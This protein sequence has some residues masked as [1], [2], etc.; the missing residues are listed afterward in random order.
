MRA[1]HDPK[2]PA[3][4]SRLVR[5]ALVAAIAV[6]AGMGGCKPEAEQLP[7]GV[8]TESCTVDADCGFGEIDHEILR[9]ADCL[10]LYGCPYLPLN[11]VSIER[12]QSQYDE[13]CEPGRNGRGQVCPIDDCIS[14]PPA[15]CVAGKC[16]PGAY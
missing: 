15:A 3:R 14:P 4:A 8:D 5:C 7:P 16:A 2:R 6:V 13:L 1:S 11:N 9:R 10:C 12:R